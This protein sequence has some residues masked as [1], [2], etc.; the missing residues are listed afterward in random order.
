MIKT[1]VIVLSP[2]QYKSDLEH[3]AA[4]AVSIARE[5]FDAPFPEVMTV[6]EI[7]RYLRFDSVRTVYNKIE[8]NGLPVTKKLG[9]PR[10]IKSEVDAWLKGD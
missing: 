3:C 1:E 6:E 8:K 9:V 10:F 7:A 5:E 4:R 2:E